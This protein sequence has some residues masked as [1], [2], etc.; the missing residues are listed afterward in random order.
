MHYDQLECPRT[1][2]ATLGDGVIYDVERHSITPGQLF[3]GGYDPRSEWSNLRSAMNK[4]FEHCASR[5]KMI[6]FVR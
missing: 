6:R 1:E 2:F 4:S 5:T 3:W